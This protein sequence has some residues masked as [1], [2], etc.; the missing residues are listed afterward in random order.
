MSANAT[1]A[2]IEQ[3]TCR[4]QS[5]QEAAAAAARGKTALP[6][7]CAPRTAERVFLQ[8]AGSSIFENQPDKTA[9]R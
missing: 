6:A 5:R 2:L 7:A 8:N 9:T 4:Q 3:R 1:Q